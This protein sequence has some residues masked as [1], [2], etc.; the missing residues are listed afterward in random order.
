MGAAAVTILSLA[1]LTIGFLV[2]WVI[3]GLNIGLNVVA[4]WALPVLVVGFLIGWLIEWLIDNQYRRIRELDQSLTESREALAANDEIAALIDAVQRILSEH[5]GEAE[6]LRVEAQDKA[7]QLARL[8]TEVEQKES[9]LED[10]RLKV[11]QKDSNLD[12]L[13]AEFDRVRTELEQKDANLVRL[14]AKFDLVRSELGQKEAHL[15]GLREE[16]DRV[17]SGLEQKAANLEQLESSYE[18]YVATHPDDLTVIKGIGQVYQEKLRQA[19]IRTYEQL[20]STTAKYLREVLEAK[21]GNKPDPQEWID[22][23]RKL[24]AQN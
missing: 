16:F 4:F 21:N 5:E 6:R 9:H 13:K 2:G 17:R 19:G 11:G 1:V 7:A 24:V 3:S 10:L 8:R 14:K 18:W 12:L 20:A 23:A 22:R 15:N